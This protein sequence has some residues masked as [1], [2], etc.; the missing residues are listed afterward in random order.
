MFDVPFAPKDDLASLFY[1]KISRA[2]SSWDANSGA[3]IQIINEYE[4]CIT[5]QLRDLFRNLNFKVLT[6]FQKN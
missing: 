3:I 4:N 2:S 6:S 5:L 1:D